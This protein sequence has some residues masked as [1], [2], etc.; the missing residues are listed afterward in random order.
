MLLEKQNKEKRILEE[1]WVHIP[2][3]DRIE[4]DS[5][6]NEKHQR[7]ITELRLKLNLDIDVAIERVRKV[8]FGNT[9]YCI[10]EK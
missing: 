3:A 1:K 10:I 6:L 9:V 7:E 4:L 2:E 8:D 5:L